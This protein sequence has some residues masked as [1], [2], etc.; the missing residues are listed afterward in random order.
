MKTRFS[1]LVRVKKSIVQKS[2][3]V[4]QSANKNLRSASSALEKAD[5]E[6][7]EVHTPLSGKITEL[8]ASR[9]LLDAQRGIIKHNE[10]W[11]AFATQELENAKQRLK[12]DMIEYEKFKYLELQ[13]INA[14]LQK[15]KMKESK[16]LDEIAVI[17]HAQKKDKVA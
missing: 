15:N 7:R 11:V 12:L 14:I 5:K 13:E 16:D 1:S 2:E 17:T 8:F 4:V 9:R 10:E 6:L 3:L